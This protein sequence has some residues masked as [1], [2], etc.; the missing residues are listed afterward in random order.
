MLG[1]E[2]RE[3]RQF[4][5]A[6]GA[7]GRPE[8]EEERPPGVIGRRDQGE[9]VQQRQ[10][11][12]GRF[13]VDH[14]ARRRWDEGGGGW[15]RLAGFQG[16]HEQGDEYAEERQDEEDEQCGGVGFYEQRYHQG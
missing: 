13:E 12:V 3:C 10:F 4:T 15:L 5:H 9:A 16:E 11:K 1:D 2:F 14:I 8:V 7:P 6:R